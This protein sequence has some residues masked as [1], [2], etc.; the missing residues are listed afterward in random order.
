MR[1]CHPG[2]RWQVGR[3]FSLFKECWDVIAMERLT[4]CEN[5]GQAAETVAVLVQVMSRSELVAKPCR[6]HFT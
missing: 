6:L 3:P 4:A 1:G 5:A 2:L